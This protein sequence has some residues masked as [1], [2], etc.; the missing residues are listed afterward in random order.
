MYNITINAKDR[1]LVSINC[2]LLI[3][4]WCAIEKVIKRLRDNFNEPFTIADICITLSLVRGY[5][6]FNPK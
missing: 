4:D 1:D 3:F 5:Q 2:I 6:I